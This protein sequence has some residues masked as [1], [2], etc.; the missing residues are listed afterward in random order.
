MLLLSGRVQEALLKRKRILLYVVV[1]TLTGALEPCE[2]Y[3]LPGGGAA[4][5]A[6]IFCGSKKRMPRLSGIPGVMR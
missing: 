3:V 4:V 5:H 6:M 2:R 1:W